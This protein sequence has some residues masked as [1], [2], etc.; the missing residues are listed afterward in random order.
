MAGTPTEVSDAPLLSGTNK[1]FPQANAVKGVELVT[2][3]ISSTTSTTQFHNG[4][5]DRIDDGLVNNISYG[6]K[7]VLDGKASTAG[8]LKMLL[9]CDEFDGTARAM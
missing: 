8:N 1:T 2:P 9:G 5:K 7:W 4:T 6:K 3:K